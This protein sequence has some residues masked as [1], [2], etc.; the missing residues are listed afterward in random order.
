MKFARF[1][2]VMQKERAISVIG[3]LREREKFPCEFVRFFG[4][5][6]GE[7]R[8]QAEQEAANVV[9]RL[10]VD[11]KFR[12]QAVQVLHIPGD[13]EYL[14]GL[15]AKLY[16]DGQPADHIRRLLFRLAPPF[17]LRPAEK[18]YKFARKFLPLP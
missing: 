18:A 1:R 13:M 9:R 8:R 6:Q 12:D 5:P 2:V 3:R 11:V 16:I 10:S 15:V 14:D 4:R 7:G 17:A